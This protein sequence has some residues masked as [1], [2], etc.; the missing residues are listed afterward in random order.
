MARGSW[1][2]AH[3]LVLVHDGSHPL[4]G[5]MFHRSAGVLILCRDGDGL[6]RPVVVIVFVV[7]AVAVVSAV[8]RLLDAGGSM[9]IS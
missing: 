6:L 3:G 8:S 5:C 2:V 7:V 4:G 9:P 1:L